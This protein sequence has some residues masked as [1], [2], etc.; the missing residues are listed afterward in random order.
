M[1]WLA[2]EKLPH[3]SPSPLQAACPL[4][5]KSLEFLR[6]SRDRFGCSC[7]AWQFCGKRSRHSSH[8][9]KKNMF[10]LHWFRSFRLPGK[11][12]CLEL[13]RAYFKHM[14]LGGQKSR[15]LSEW[16]PKLIKSKD[17]WELDH[18]SGCTTASLSIS[19][20]SQ[21]QCP[22]VCPSSPCSAAA[23]SELCPVSLV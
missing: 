15:K 3:V 6:G 9:G 17:V 23:D 2:P 11:G 13:L 18:S 4:T 7:G 12:S 1:H 21:N 8:R 16:L 10:L 14:Y 5:W 19:S 22:S 20:Y